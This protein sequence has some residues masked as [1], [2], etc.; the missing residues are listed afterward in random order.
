[1]LLTT[2]FHQIFRLFIDWSINGLI[3]K[4]FSA[5]KGGWCVCISSSLRLCLLLS[6]LPLS[7]PMLRLLS[8]KVQGRKDS[9]KLSK[10]CHVGTHWKAL[11]EYFQMS[12]HLPGFWHFCGICIGKISHQQHKGGLKLLVLFV[13]CYC[14]LFQTDP[15]DD[16]EAEG[17]NSHRALVG[18]PS[19]PALHLG[20]GHSPTSQIF[21]FIHNHPICIFFLLLILLFF[22]LCT[23]LRNIVIFDGGG[24]WGVYGFKGILRV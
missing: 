24:C 5:D 16:E 6:L 14:I 7:L 15:T 21:V 13:H 3:P 23:F 1:M 12:T 22:F 20:Y 9:W 8:S 17:G 2:R 10:P 11:T 18:F 4:D 19:C